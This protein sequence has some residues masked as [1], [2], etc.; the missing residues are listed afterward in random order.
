MHQGVNLKLCVVKGVLGG[1]NH[2]AIDYLSYPRIQTHLSGRQDGYV[3]F[4]DYPRFFFDLVWTSFLLQVFACQPEQ[5]VFFTVFASKESSEYFSTLFT[6]HEL[7]KRVS[8]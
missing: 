7:F 5:N 2:V 6:A 4:V 3:I 1:S 8:P